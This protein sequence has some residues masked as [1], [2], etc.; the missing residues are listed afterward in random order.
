MEALNDLIRSNEKKQE[1]EIKAEGKEL[2]DGGWS[3]K[4][5]NSINC[6]YPKAFSKAILQS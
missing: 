4:Y 3:K 2:T 6:K 1:G 5:K